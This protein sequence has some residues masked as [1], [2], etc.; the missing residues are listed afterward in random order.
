MKF[1]VKV[2]NGPLKKWLHFGGDPDQR[3]DI[4]LHGLFSGFVII[5]RYGKWLT[6]INLSFIHSDSPDGGSW[7]RDTGKTGFVEGR[8]CPSASSSLLRRRVT[9]HG[10]LRRYRA[11]CGNYWSEFI[12]LFQKKIQ[13]HS[14]VLS[15]H[16]Q[17]V[18]FDYHMSWG[19]FFMVICS[20]QQCRLKYFS[21][22]IENTNSLPTT[23]EK[24]HRTTL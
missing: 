19:T 12:I 1:S 13:S 15:F 16:Q 2:G 24:C 3:L 7:Y 23:P 21:C 14:S 22:V 6:G 11:V 5:G 4:G 9:S 8:H 18:I 17:N 20:Y 10:M